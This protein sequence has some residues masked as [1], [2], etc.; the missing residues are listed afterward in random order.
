MNSHA[1]S[2]EM[3]DL[4]STNEHRS[5]VNSD[6]DTFQVVLIGVLLAALAFGFVLGVLPGQ[7]LG[8]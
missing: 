6:S 1:P 7:P 4:P 3:D 8:G 5:S 2:D